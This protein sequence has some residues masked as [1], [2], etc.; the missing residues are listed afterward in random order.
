[1]PDEIV[2]KPIESMSQLEKDIFYGE[3]KDLSDERKQF[4]KDF[5]EEEIMEGFF[6]A[7]SDVLSTMNKLNQTLAGK[8]LLI[9]PLYLQA[10]KFIAKHFELELVIDSRMPGPCFIICVKKTENIEN[11]IEA[12]RKTYA[13]HVQNPNYRGMIS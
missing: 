5:A 1:M 7:V 10:Y 6:N 12:T 9:S 4:A 11:S 8:C 13:V 3:Y 2:R